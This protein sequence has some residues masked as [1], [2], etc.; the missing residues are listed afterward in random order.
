VAEEIEAA[1]NATDKDVEIGG[2]GLAAAEIELGLV[3]ELRMFDNPVVVGAA[4]LSCH[5]SS[6]TFRWTWS[7][8]GP[9]ARA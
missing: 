3:D 8:P 5:R 7:R 6:M 4:R 1:L 2:A 9:S